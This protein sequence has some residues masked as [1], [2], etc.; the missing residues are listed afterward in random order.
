MIKLVVNDDKT[1]EIDVDKF[2]GEELY[3]LSMSLIEEYLKAIIENQPKEY[4]KEICASM[5]LG[6]GVVA[7]RIDREY[8]EEVKPKWEIIKGGKS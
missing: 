5:Q 1:I 6:L 2:E 3:S 7:A 8:D 4:K